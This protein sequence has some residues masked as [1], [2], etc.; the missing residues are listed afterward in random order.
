MSL[1]TI[2][3]NQ[4][5]LL[6]DDLRLSKTMD[7]EKQ[8]LMY[9]VLKK[10]VE[11]RKLLS[12]VDMDFKRTIE[13]R[14]DRLQV[15]SPD[16]IKDWKFNEG[17]LVLYSE[18]A[19]SY[20]VYSSDKVTNFVQDFSTILK[21]KGNVFEVI[22]DD[23]P[24]RLVF[25]VKHD[26][27]DEHIMVF[28]QLLLEFIRDNKKYNVTPSDIKIFKDSTGPSINVEIIVNSIILESY[29]E[30]ESFVDDF[31]KYLLEGNVTHEVVSV[32][33]KIDHKLPKAMGLKGQLL[34]APYLK[35]QI[36]PQKGDDRPDRIFDGMATPIIINNHNNNTIV[37]NGDVITGGVV[38]K[39]NVTIKHKTVTT[40][41]VYNSSN[42]NPRDFCQYVYEIQ[43]DWYLENQKVPMSVI[44]DAYLDYLNDPNATVKDSSLSRSLGDLMFA[45]SQKFRDNMGNAVKK[46]YTYSKMREQVGF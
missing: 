8:K 28:K 16:E 31:K 18:N 40:N 36:I 17:S 12:K 14:T 5:D 38:N 7:P 33:D 21:R 41:N 32:V 6:L 3:E 27:L 29:Y 42:K 30:K 43:P 25:I 26:M 24:Q 2:S 13:S 34:K 39:G 15:I 46:L 35:T 9:T 22:L 37:V 45:K 11:Q 44:L 10:A 4:F 23:N 20:L 19:G 1:T